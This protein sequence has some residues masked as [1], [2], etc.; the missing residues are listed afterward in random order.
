M[1]I[2]IIQVDLHNPR[3]G[4]YYDEIQELVNKYLWGDH[5]LETVNALIVELIDDE[6]MFF[7]EEEFP[8]A[9][10]SRCK[11]SVISQDTFIKLQQNKML[12]SK[13]EYSSDM[14]GNFKYE[15]NEFIHPEGEKNYLYLNMPCMVFFQNNIVT[16][17][18]LYEYG[19]KF[20]SYS[21]SYDDLK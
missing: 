5:S 3:S 11:Y 2:G 8:Y 16:F 20:V 9:E 14:Y 6:L 7:A 15:N 18:I 19:D 10:L 13:L 17:F 4:S 12:P 1:A 21:L